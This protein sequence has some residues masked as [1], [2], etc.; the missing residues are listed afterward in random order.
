MLDEIEGALPGCR[1]DG[2]ARDPLHVR[3]DTLIIVESTMPR[4]DL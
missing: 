3:E 1:I 2:F 4:H